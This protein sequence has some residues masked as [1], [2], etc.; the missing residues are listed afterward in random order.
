MF[1]EGRSRPVRRADSLIAFWADC[2][3]NVEFLTSHNKRQNIPDDTHGLCKH[4]NMSIEN[5]Y[6]SVDYLLTYVST[7]VLM[8]NVHWASYDITLLK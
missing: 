8:Y 3:D 5:G 1:L 4:F 6:E 2:L 7:D